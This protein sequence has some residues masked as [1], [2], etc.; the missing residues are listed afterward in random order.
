MRNKKNLLI[1]HLMIA[2]LLVIGVVSCFA[3][4]GTLQDQSQQVDIEDFTYC[5]FLGGNNDDRILDVAT[6]SQGNFIVA[7]F[8]MSTDFP[9]RNPHQHSY[10]G[11]GFDVHGVSGD[12]FIAKFDKEE[13][14]LWSTYLG[15]SSNDGA[16]HV[17][18]VT[19]YSIV[20]LGLTKS[21]DFPTTTNAYQQD[22]SANYDIFIAKFTANGSVIYSSYL[23]A[24]GDETLSD[25]E[26]DSSGNLVILGT[27]N[28]SNFPVT[29][30]AHQPVIGGGSDLFLMRLSANCSTILYSTFLGGNDFE[31]L[32]DFA[33]D[34]QG[35]I[36]VSGSTMS[37]DFPITEDAFQDSINGIEREAFIAKYNSSGQLTYATYFGGSHADDCFGIEVDSSGNIIMAGRTWSADLPTVN[38]WKANYTNN[39]ANPQFGELPDG[40]ITKF[41]ADAQ[42][43]NFSSYFGG[44]GWDHV[45]CVDVDSKGNII[46]SGIADAIVGGTIESNAFPILDAFQEEIYGRCDIII[47]MI[48]P[49]GE[50]LFGTYLGG[51]G[52]DHPWSQYLTNDYLYITG[53]TESQ[54]FP[55]TSTAYQ[56]TYNRNID[57]YIF[58]F[59]IDGYLEALY[60]ETTTTITTT[61]PST[62]ALTTT[63]TT[64]ESRSSPS[65]EIYL[66]FLGIFS[67]LVKNRIKTRKRVDG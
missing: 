57:G 58:R 8:T 23:G 53:H 45:G 51:V 12:A 54:D 9:V 21:N 17:N 15:G 19:D 3:T 42:E 55:V 37:S 35:N 16:T 48:S 13:Q 66:T 61:T 22:Y 36:I 62:T 38:A 7:G 14:L 39:E 4:S 20:V 25:F 1:D 27:T 56:Q 50:P 11:G 33:I 6:D 44:S 30:S 31:G 52:I 65:F 43:L 40:Y 34:A 24:I 29:A 63:E 47:M 28:S 60:S 67:V 46:V 5:T 2:L 64:T 32:S 18:V 10:A 26:V 41:S 59:D 49:N